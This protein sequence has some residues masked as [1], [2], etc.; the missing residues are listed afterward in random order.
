MLTV[1]DTAIVLFAWIVLIGW[2]IA[3]VCAMVAV[4][5]WKRER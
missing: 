4:L 1:D 2:A 5:E 3:G